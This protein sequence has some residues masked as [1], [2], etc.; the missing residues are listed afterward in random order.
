M[1]NNGFSKTEA[2]D[3]AESENFVVPKY[4]YKIKKYGLTQD[5]IAYKLGVNNTC[6]NKMLNLAIPMQKGVEKDLIKILEMEKKDYSN[7]LQRADKKIRV[8]TKLYS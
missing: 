8:K 5:F 2:L 3:I 7:G 4:K 1:L 6:L